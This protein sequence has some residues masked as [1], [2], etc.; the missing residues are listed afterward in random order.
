CGPDIC[1]W[2][3]FVLRY[4]AN[5]SERSSINAREI[6]WTVFSER[7]VGV[8]SGALFNMSV[9]SLISG[10]VPRNRK[11]KTR[12]SEL[13]DTQRASYKSFLISRLSIKWSFTLL[14]RLS[15]WH[16]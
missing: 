11:H 6:S 2:K 5:T 15:E 12:L 9:T 8:A 10:R 16:A 13:H 7:V 4:N 1:Q 14:G 3:F